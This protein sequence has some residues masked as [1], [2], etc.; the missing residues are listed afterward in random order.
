MI[1]FLFHN[2]SFGKSLKDEV[3]GEKDYRQGDELGI[4]QN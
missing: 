2:N 1:T 3:E 4:I